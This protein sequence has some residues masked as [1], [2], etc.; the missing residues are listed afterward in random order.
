MNRWRTRMSPQVLVGTVVTYY[1]HDRVLA[2]LQ[3][4]FSCQGAT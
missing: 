3:S 1:E 4:A 2:S